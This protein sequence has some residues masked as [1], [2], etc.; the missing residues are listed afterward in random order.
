MKERVRQIKVRRA[1]FLFFDH[2]LLR[3]PARFPI[4]LATEE[5]KWEIHTLE[6]LLPLGFGPGNLKK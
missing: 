1:W 2:D 4:I 3:D 5:G 6:E